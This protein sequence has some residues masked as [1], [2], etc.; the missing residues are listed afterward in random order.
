VLYNLHT[1]EV[2]ISDSLPSMP[3]LFIETLQKSCIKP[4]VVVHTCNLRELRQE[5]LK[6]KDSLDYVVEFG[7]SAETS[8]LPLPTCR[9]RREQEPRSEVLTGSWVEKQT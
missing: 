1:S 8:E 2:I 5:D 4:G 3:L 7:A 6:F 9:E